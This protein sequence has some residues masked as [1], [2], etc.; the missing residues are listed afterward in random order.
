MPLTQLNHDD[1]RARFRGDG[2]RHLLG[3]GFCQDAQ[4]L[5]MI[6]VFQDT[7]IVDISVHDFLSFLPLMTQ[8]RRA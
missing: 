8:V 2:S 5:E 3:F 6:K 1:R 4:A 7:E